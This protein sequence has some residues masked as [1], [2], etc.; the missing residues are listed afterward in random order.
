LL[1]TLVRKE[2]NAWTQAVGQRKP[3]AGA[4]SAQPKPAA[5]PVYPKS[6]AQPARNGADYGALP[7]DFASAV[8]AAL[9]DLQ[10][11]GH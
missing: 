5:V 10:E 6:N 3:A 9:R 8:D 11:Y 7:L 2:L 1:E 4:P